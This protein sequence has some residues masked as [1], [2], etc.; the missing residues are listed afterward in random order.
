MKG[1]PNFL[2][3]NDEEKQRDKALK[4]LDYVRWVLHDVIKFGEVCKKFI[5]EKQRLL[6]YYKT[7]MSQGLPVDLQGQW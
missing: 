7:K 1:I 3:S 5:K 2:L 6:F 4:E